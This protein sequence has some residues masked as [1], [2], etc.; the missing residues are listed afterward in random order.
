[1]TGGEHVLAIDL[2]T[3]G[4]KVAIVSPDGEIVAHD[5]EPVELLLL[6]DGAEQD[7]DDWWRAITTA[8]RRLPGRDTVSAVCVSGQ[9]GGTVPVSRTGQHLHNAL[10]WMDG[11]GAPEVARLVG[12]GLELPGTGYNARKLADWLRRNGG[13]PSLTGKD[14]VGQMHWLAQHRPDVYARTATF[15]DVPEYLT[16]RL[17]GVA[18]ATYDS[19]AMRWCTDNRD[20]RRIR[21]DERLLAH[22]GLDRARLP[23][24]REPATVVGPILR[25]AARELGVGE[26]VQVVTGTG[27]TLAA[28]VGSGAI[29]DFDTHLYVGTSSWL[30][31]HVPFKRTD[32]RHAIAS[33]PSIVPGRYWVA[34]IQDVAGKAIDWLIDNVVWADDGLTGEARPQDALAR[35]NDLAAKAPPASNGVLFLPWLNGE[36]TPVEN[37]SL[38][39]GWF[40][41]GLVSSRATL[42]R[43]VFEGVALNARWMRDAVER[44]VAKGGGP[45][46][47][48]VRF[49]G[50]GASS[51][52]WC[53]IMA[54]VLDVSVRQ[55]RDPTLA[56]VR[57]AGLIA[58]VALGR[59]RWTDIPDRV[60]IA[61]TYDP[62][63]ANRAAYDQA[64]ATFR[65]Y[66]RR[67][68]PLYAAT[69]RARP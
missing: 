4:P 17:S 24:L 29:A 35:L 45:P 55:V 48:S 63:P 42:A 68:R 57:G 40:N 22:C 67:T 54:D 39:G 6:G 62:D 31:C 11:R 15:L 43:S 46:A 59:L 27:D 51:P 2:G 18:T 61:E 13:L 3:S 41:V 65:T 58:L 64:Y 28:A 23:D 66:Y 52:L 9:W 69:Q 16:M 12:G 37:P 14:P 32:A 53:Q 44:F 30:S 36:R 49:I 19:I 56:N 1:M 5:F 21:Y 20:V 10:I 7:P 25:S 50:G 47:R 60:Q 26:H 38:R 8:V 34:S 33:L